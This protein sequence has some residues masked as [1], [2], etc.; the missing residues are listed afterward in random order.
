[1][2]NYTFK[3]RLFLFC[4]VESSFRFLGMILI[5]FLLCWPGSAAAEEI[6]LSQALEKFYQNNYDILISRFEIDKSQADLVGA[7]LWPNPTFSVNYTGLDLQTPPV[8]NDNTQ[9]TFRLDQLF[10]LGGKR[11]HRTNQAQET[12]EASKLGH[13]DTIRTLLTGFYTFFF[14]LKLD[15]LNV[16]LS[17]DELK[18][19]DRSLTVAEKRFNAGHMSLVDYTKIKIGRI[20]LEN[21]LTTTETQLKNDQEQF[22]FLIGSPKIVTPI[23]PVNENLPVYGEDLLIPRALENRYDLLALQKQLKAAEFGQAL[24]KA[25]RI[26]DLT[27]GAEYET[28]GAGSSPGIGL[29]ISIPIPFFNRNQGDIL[30]KKAEYQQLELQIQKLKKQIEVDIRQALNNFSQSLRVLEAYKGRKSEMTDLLERSEKAFALGGVTVLD[31]LDT[32]KTYRDFMNK[33]NQALVQSNLNERLIKIY[34]GELK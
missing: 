14:N 32:Q 5:W 15:S 26:P 34:T 23:V 12:L 11:G 19:Y 17:Q 31:W 13:K 20:D 1:M 28:F 21:N 3:R 16:E 30:R 2:T 25:G 10:E 22:R 9:L 27:V 18:R 7:K 4:S 24:A 29:G 33:F 8:A 6:D